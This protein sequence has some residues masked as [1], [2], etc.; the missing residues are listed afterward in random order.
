[1]PSRLAPQPPTR[2][3]SSTTSSR[4]V[5]A[6]DSSTV[7]WSSGRSERRSTTSAWMPSPASSSAA[8][9]ESRTP[10]S[11]D[12]MVTSLPSRTTAALP[13]GTVSSVGGSPFIE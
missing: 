1:M 4:F 9:S 3:P 12:T 13:S 6:T 11:A 5:L 2:V 10:L 7:S 8:S